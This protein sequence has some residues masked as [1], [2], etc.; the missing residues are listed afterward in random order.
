M[1]H[2]Y[3]NVA[4]I[5]PRTRVLGPGQRF[6]I[7]VQGCCFDCPQC[8]SPAWRARKPAKLFTIPELSE[9]ILQTSDIEGIT[10]SGGEPMLQAGKLHQLVSQV[11]A[12]RP[13]TVIC[14]TGFTLESLR[15][16]GAQDV[17][18]FLKNIDV[19]IDGPYIDKLNNDTGLR[20]SSN[21]GIHFLTGMY[22]DHEHQ[23]LNGQRNLEMHLFEARVLTVGI[24]ARN[25]KK[26][27]R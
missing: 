27:V 23:F 1:T 25:W 3:L 22:K 7:W 18:D 4:S 11:K 21:Q 10:L 14:Y 20:G 6:V 8:I 13:L 2:P 5:C 17:I 19:L 9:A 24:H 12:V 26:P 16:T 15:E